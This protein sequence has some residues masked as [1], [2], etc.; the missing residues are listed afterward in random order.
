MLKT[1]MLLLELPLQSLFAVPVQKIDT[2]VSFSVP[3]VTTSWFPFVHGEIIFC[4]LHGL[5]KH[6]VTFLLLECM[7]VL[8]SIA[9]SPMLQ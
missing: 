8:C 5:S 7:H 4:S 9:M 1:M 3:L 2:T 6:F